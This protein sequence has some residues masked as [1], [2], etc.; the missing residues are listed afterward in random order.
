MRL[1]E[2]PLSGDDEN[3]WTREEGEDPKVVDRCGG[4]HRGVGL[5]SSW[6]EAVGR[7]GRGESI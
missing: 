1:D 4:L 2:F 7:H 6:M 3:Q 5:V